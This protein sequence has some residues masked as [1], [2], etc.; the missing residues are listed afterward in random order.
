M[1]INSRSLTSLEELG[2][3]EEIENNGHSFA[4]TIKT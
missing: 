4:I 1:V 3:E 2:A